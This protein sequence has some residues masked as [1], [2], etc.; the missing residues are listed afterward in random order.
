MAGNGPAQAAAHLVYGSRALINQAVVL[1]ARSLAAL[2]HLA[3]SV[4][5][6]HRSEKGL[7]DLLGDKIGV[8]A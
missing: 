5:E 2:L 4:I 3:M 8:V 1:V 6:A 7:R